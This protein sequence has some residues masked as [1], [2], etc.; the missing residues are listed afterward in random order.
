MSVLQR[1]PPP[2]LQS[3][4]ATLFHRFEVGV[5]LIGLLEVVFG[6]LKTGAVQIAMV[7]DL[8]TPRATLPSPIPATPTSTRSPVACTDIRIHNLRFSQYR[9]VLA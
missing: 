8:S 4:Y 7:P 9:R 5:G 1:H 6:V 2:R 3:S